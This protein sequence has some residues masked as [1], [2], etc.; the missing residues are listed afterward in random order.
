MEPM[1]EKA[2]LIREEFECFVRIGMDSHLRTRVRRALEQRLI[3][4]N[5]FTAMPV[6]YFEIRNEDGTIR[7][8]WYLDADSGQQLRLLEFLRRFNIDQVRLI[9]GMLHR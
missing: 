1:T 5:P 3:S 7:E 8:M 9:D 6:I 4:G 2:Q